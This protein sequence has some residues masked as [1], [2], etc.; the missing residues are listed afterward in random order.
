MRDLSHQIF[1]AARRVKEDMKTGYLFIEKL[2]DEVKKTKGRSS[3]TISAKNQLNSISKDDFTKLFKS[4]KPVFVLAILDTAVIQRELDKIDL[5]SSNIAKFSLNEL[6]KNMR[7][8]AVDFRI[9]EI[10]K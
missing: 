4:R 9:Y 3:Y 1:I 7:N 2:Y 10:K 6:I 8:L 5:F